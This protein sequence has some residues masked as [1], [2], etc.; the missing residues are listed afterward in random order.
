MVDVMN[1]KILSVGTIIMFVCIGLSGCMDQT[2]KTGEIE[3]VS[4]SVKTEAYSHKTGWK[5]FGE[6]FQPD[7]LPEI[8]IREPPYLSEEF[9]HGRYNITV[10]VKNI[11]GYNLSKI[12]ITLIFYDTNGSQLFSKQLNDFSDLPDAHT[13]ILGW[14]YDMDDSK[15]GEYFE[16][17]GNINISIGAQ[18]ITIQPYDFDGL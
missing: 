16:D 1:R 5:N 11:A 9:T 15:Y 10:T 3:L 6:G 2:E 13:R 18:S 4:Y 8:T 14:E 7:A 17:I 12:L